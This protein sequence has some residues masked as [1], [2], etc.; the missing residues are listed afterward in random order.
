MIND[1]VLNY[2]EHILKDDKGNLPFEV[3]HALTILRVSAVFVKLAMQASDLKF[4]VKE[5]EASH[6]HLETI[7]TESTHLLYDI[8]ECYL[9]DIQD[10][11][12]K[13]MKE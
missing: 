6:C 10:M 4:V 13:E 2:Y 8:E 1:S 9:Q 3:D 7:A 12:D 11:I 5:L